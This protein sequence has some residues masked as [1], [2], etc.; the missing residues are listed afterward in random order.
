MCA[1]TYTHTRTHPD[2]QQPQT[3]TA[4]LSSSPS[5]SSVVKLRSHQVY[6]PK[7]SR[8]KTKTQEEN[9]YE[10]ILKLTPESSRYCVEWERDK[11]AGVVVVV[12]DGVVREERASLRRAGPSPDPRRPGRSAEGNRVASP[13][14]CPPRG[15]RPAPGSPRSL[16]YHL[17][18]DLTTKEEPRR[19]SGG[20]EIQSRP[21]PSE[22][23]V[24]SS[25]C[26]LFQFLRVSGGDLRTR[27]GRSPRK[28]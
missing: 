6:Q 25:S 21:S 23:G 26:P 5:R 12:V 16:P 19:K 1:Y 3:H 20:G 18:K 28:P 24:V 17:S 27:S 4:S 2:Q 13:G 22:E 9:A 11:K 7:G 15:Y 10:K 14:P 8:D